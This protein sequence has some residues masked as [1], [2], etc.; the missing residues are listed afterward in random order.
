[1]ETWEAAELIAQ[2]DY[3]Q[4]AE[5]EQTRTICYL[6]TQINSTKSLKPSDIIKFKWDT[7]N[8]V[9]SE[10]IDEAEEKKKLAEINI[11]EKQFEKLY[12]EKKI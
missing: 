9:E 4:R 1:M 10:Q 2:Y 3:Y 11:L 7:D 8:D 5:W 6:L 12:A